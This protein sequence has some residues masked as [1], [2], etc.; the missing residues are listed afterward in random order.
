MNCNFLNGKLINIL[1]ENAS[2]EM[3]MLE[4]DSLEELLDDW[5]GE[6]AYVPSNDEAVYF[7]VY[8]GEPI[9]PD[10]YTNFESLL[11]VLQT[12]YGHVK[13]WDKDEAWDAIH[14]LSDMK[15]KYDVFDKEEREKYHACSLAIKALRE[16]IKE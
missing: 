7:A 9:N 15:A 12:L 10:M 14:E 5:N 1:T 3:Y 8:D 11:N 6:C 13:S 4:A 16:V 2:G